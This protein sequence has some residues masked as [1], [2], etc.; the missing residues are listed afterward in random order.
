MPD[1]HYSYVDLQVVHESKASRGCVSGRNGKAAA[2]LTVSL[3]SGDMELGNVGGRGI[4]NPCRAS[5]NSMVQH[6]KRGG[7]QCS[8]LQVLGL[9]SL[10]AGLPIPCYE[11]HHNRG[12]PG[13]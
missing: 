7:T 12:R 2:T 8:Q 10:W 6:A 11:R 3:S 5:G 13:T 1:Q 4:H 9:P